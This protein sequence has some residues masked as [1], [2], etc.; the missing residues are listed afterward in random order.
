M[1]GERRRRMFRHDLRPTVT[2][3]GAWAVVQ[4]GHREWWRDRDWPLCPVRRDGVG[5]LC[6]LIYAHSGG[7]EWEQEVG[8]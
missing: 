8:A 5:P 4:T 6:V 1:T 3:A 7:H 2:A